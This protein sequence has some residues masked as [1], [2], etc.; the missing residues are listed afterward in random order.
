MAVNAIN[1]EVPLVVSR[2]RIDVEMTTDT[3]D[4]AASSSPPTGFHHPNGRDVSTMECR[5]LLGATEPL[6]KISNQVLDPE[7]TGTYAEGDPFLVK[8]QEIDCDLQKFENVPCEE[9][10][11]AVNKQSAQVLQIGGNQNG[12]IGLLGS[13]IGEQKKSGEKGKS[14]VSKGPARDGKIGVGPNPQKEIKK[15]LWTRINRPI[16][17]T[18]E[19]VSY[20]A[21]GLKR[22]ARETQ[23]R[24]EFNTKKE[25]KQKI[26]EVTNKQSV[27]SA[28]QWASTKVAEQPRR[29]Q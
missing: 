26:E 1:V 25:K 11:C 23:A 5:S 27:L 18:G 4:K 24:E 15:G 14:K 20:G 22:K 6:P 3:L 19:E 10:E 28:T 21:D 8:L 9:R 17:D 16:Y 7:I 29:E 12:E 13:T 2:S